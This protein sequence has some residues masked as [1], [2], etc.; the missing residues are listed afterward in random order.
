MTVKIRDIQSQCVQELEYQSG[1]GRLTVTFTSGAVYDY[2][3]VP[4]A[5]WKELLSVIYSTLSLGA[6]MGKNIFRSF[7]YREVKKGC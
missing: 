4:V 5:V 7:E 2:K 6:W 3:H 1:T